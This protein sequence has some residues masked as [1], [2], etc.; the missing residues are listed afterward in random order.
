MPFKTTFTVNKKTKGNKPSDV[1]ELNVSILEETILD[2]VKNNK[3]ARYSKLV[4]GFSS[5][6]LVDGAANK[7]KQEPSMEE[8]IQSAMDAVP[9][10]SANTEDMPEIEYDVC[11]ENVTALEN[12]ILAAIG[13]GKGNNLITRS[14]NKFKSEAEIEASIR[15]A[16]D[17]VPRVNSKT[18]VS[19]L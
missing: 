3:R 1:S 17:S 18:D 2:T 11:E 15:A 19:R 9:R 13:R 14:K 8:S 7:S 4:D 10:R 6:N 12:A 16:M 5:I